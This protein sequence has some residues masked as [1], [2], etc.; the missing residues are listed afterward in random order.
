MSI[1]FKRFDLILDKYRYCS[2]KILDR[3]TVIYRLGMRDKIFC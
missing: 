3:M 1:F 2:K